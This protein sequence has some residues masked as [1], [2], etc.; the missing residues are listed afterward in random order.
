VVIKRSRCSEFTASSQK[1][2]AKHPLNNSFW[3][4]FL[5]SGGFIA[6]ADKITD[7]IEVS[8]SE[9][10]HHREESSS[11]STGHWFALLSHRIRHFLLSLMIA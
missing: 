7:L 10:G 8:E 9:R 1:S 2:P 4:L 6:G 3:G 11:R 5:I